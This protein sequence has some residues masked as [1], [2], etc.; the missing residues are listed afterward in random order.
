[1]AQSILLAPEIF[2]SVVALVVLVGEAFKPSLRRFWIH[3]AA[4]A[5]VACLVHQ[6]L[7]FVHKSFPWATAVGVTPTSATRGW[8]E[9]RDVFGMLSIDSLAIFFKIALLASSAIVLWLSADYFEFNDSPLGTYAG[10][11]LLGTVGMMLLV[12][13]ADLLMAVIAIELL[14]ISSF[15]LTGFVPGRRSSGE[16]A[17]KFFLVGAL[18]TA[19]FLFGVSYYYG[20]FGTTGISALQAMGAGQRPDVV[21]GLIIVFLIAGIAFKLTIVPFHMWAPDAFEGAPTPVTAFLSAG[22]KAAVLGFL[23][24]LLANHQG[25][26]LTPLLAVLAALTMTVGNLGALHQTNVKRLLAYSSVAQVG[27]ILTALVA[28]GPLGFSGA[29]L[30]TIVYLV[31][32]LGAFAGLLMVSN[33]SRSDDVPAFAGLSR[34][35]LGL[36]LSM[37]VFLLSLTGIPPLAGFVGKYIIFSSVLQ[38]PRLAWLAILAAVNSVVSFY[39]YFRIAHEMFF[40]EPIDGARPVIS[41]ALLSCLL[42]ALALTLA[43]G[44]A[45]NPFLG[46]V[47]NVVGS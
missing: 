45:P 8:I 38:A 10:L 32:N 35:S 5:L 24:R 47:R 28:G 21:V 4:A 7:F 25:L 3:A 43:I 33:G 29:L 36:A 13:A 41:P 42:A 19:V 44:L 30:Y 46:W 37:T 18:S 9:Y 11:V 20:Y 17:L 16:A 27:Y 12:S 15:V 14:S 31:M 26:G 2:L 23:L 6:V 39:F 1:M 40:R 34:K 22:P